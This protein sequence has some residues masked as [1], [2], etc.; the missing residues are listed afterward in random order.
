MKGYLPYS[1]SRVIRDETAPGQ[2]KIKAK[3]F[4]AQLLANNCQ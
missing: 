2:F 3:P 1:F 4:H